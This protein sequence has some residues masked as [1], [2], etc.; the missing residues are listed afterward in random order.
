MEKAGEGAIAHGGIVYCRHFRLKKIY[1][2]HPSG[3]TWFQVPDCPVQYFSM[4]FVNGMLTKVG[5]EKDMTLGFARLAKMWSLEIQ[6]PTSLSAS[7]RM[8]VLVTGWKYT[9]IR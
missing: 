9:T 8:E 5:G 4:A 3:E 7:L 1:L 2:F 6:S